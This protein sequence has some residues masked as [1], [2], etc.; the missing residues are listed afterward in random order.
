M[1]NEKL[2]MEN[3]KLRMRIPTSGFAR[4]GMTSL[5]PGMSF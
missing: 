4:L 1:K 2:K 5:F 3:G